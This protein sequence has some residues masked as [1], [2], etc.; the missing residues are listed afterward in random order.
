[1]TALRTGSASPFLRVGLDYYDASEAKALS[2]WPYDQVNTAGR[3]SAFQARGLIREADFLSYYL[4]HRSTVD[5][6]GT[7]SQR[8]GLAESILGYIRP[9]ITLQTGTI[10]ST[11]AD[12]VAGDFAERIGEAVGLAVVSRMHGLTE[13][14]WA[15]LRTIP[16]KHGIPTFDFEIASDSQRIIQL[17]AK[18][19]IVADNQYSAIPAVRQHAWNIKQKKNKL[20][21]RAV[22]QMQDPYP[23][24]I[25]YGTIA[26]IDAQHD[27][28]C[29]LLDPPETVLEVPPQ[30]LRLLKR[31][32]FVASFV[33]FLAPGATLPDALDLRILEILDSDAPLSVWDRKPLP[34]VSGR[35]YFS[36]ESYV[37]LFLSTGRTYLP[38]EGV[39][40]VV[41]RLPS[42]D[43]F[44]FG[45]RKE[46]IESAIDQDF[47]RI[48]EM[49]FGRGA[50]D[51]AS[52]ELVIP[53]D[54]IRRQG[55]S[56]EGLYSSS[57]VVFG[58]PNQSL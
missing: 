7:F 22:E 34:H 5:G 4:I 44:F 11:T 23:A 49:N 52:S 6:H 10:R 42:G 8:L 20:R 12:R 3:V 46:P 14:D 58:I 48:L 2:E 40:G 45:I 37:S 33:R 39:V 47:D 15:V 9:V 31:L 35:G 18:G 26:V 56:F 30:K 43:P 50:E 19:S 55:V 29:W 13:A 16:G 1:M 54:G 41:S 24:L 53:I 38:D 28:R 25:R 36:S 32:S 17:E 57:G 27:T 21:G 51:S